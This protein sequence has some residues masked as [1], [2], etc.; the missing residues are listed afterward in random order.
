[1]P[2]SVD[3]ALT[4]RPDD[5]GRSLVLTAVHRSAVKPSDKSEYRNT[6][7][8]DWPQKDDPHSSDL[9]GDAIR[10]YVA[11]PPPSTAEQADNDIDDARSDNECVCHAT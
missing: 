1:M 10:R 8:P 6:D 5:E 11:P 7:Q 9:A 4:D 3:I 2:R